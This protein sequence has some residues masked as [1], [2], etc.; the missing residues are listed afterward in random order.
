VSAATLLDR[1]ERVK[2]AG[3]GRWIACCPAHKDRTPSLSIRELDDGRVLLHD[4][5]G[6]DIE[7][8]LASLGLTVGDLFAKPLGEFR[9]S[10]SAIPA[11]DLLVLLDH[12]IT[13]AVIILDEIVTRRAV[14]ECQLQ[15]LMTASVRIGKAR[16]IACP[17]KVASHA[18]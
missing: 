4:F 17:A 14:N 13:V 16:D 9:P 2:Q 11:R 7:N 5:G 8:V 15:R 3:P 6:C 1:L 10:Q 12:E 18:A